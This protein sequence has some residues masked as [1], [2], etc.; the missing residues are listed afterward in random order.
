MNKELLKEYAEVKGQIK[1]LTAKAK[2]MEVEVITETKKIITDLGSANLKTDVGTF[3]LTE[4]KSYTYS[5]DYKT[6]EV[7]VAEDILPIEEK[8]KPMQEEIKTIKQTLSDLASEEEKSGKA[9]C[10]VKDGLRFTPKK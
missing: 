8:M 10:E 3:S 6:A 9:T 7:K 1:E 4:S 2:G 5:E